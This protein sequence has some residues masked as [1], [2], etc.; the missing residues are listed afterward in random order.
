MR[1]RIRETL[2]RISALLAGCTQGKQH[3][4]EWPFWLPFLV[5]QKWTDRYMRPIWFQRSL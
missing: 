5:T 1:L 4:S 2:G 3:S